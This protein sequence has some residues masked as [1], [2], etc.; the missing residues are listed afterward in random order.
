MFAKRDAM[1]ADMS[2][3]INARA[4]ISLCLSQTPLRYLSVTTLSITFSHSQLYV[5]SFTRFRRFSPSICSLFSLADFPALAPLLPVPPVFAA[6]YLYDNISK[7]INFFLFPPPKSRTQSADWSTR[8]IFYKILCAHAHAYTGRA[9]VTRGFF[10][11]ILYHHSN[12]RCYKLYTHKNSER[13]EC[14][15]RTLIIIIIICQCVRAYVSDKY[16][17]YYYIN[18]ICK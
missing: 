9:L 7:T 8:I 15:I 10:S 13:S 18:Q 17:L 5:F 6:Q 4:L 14:L 16:R 2:L 1:S 11:I 3:L 12:G